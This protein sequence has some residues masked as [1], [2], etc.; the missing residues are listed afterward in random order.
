MIA[1]LSHHREELYWS[2]KELHK[3][4]DAH[5]TLGN[6]AL[7]DGLKEMVATIDAVIDDLDEILNN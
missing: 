4:A 1:K 5:E 7:S 2:V 6:I 3:I